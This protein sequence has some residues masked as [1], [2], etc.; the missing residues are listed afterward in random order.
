MFTIHPPVSVTFRNLSFAYHHDFCD[1]FVLNA[2]M[3]QMMIAATVK[4]FI[5]STKI[6]VDYIFAIKDPPLLER[7]PK[8]LVRHE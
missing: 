8:N 2:W 5:I 7:R 6:A 4:V 3:F 1:K